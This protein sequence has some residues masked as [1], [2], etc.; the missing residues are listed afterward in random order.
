MAKD[1]TP[2]APGN[3]PS[4]QPMKQNETKQTPIQRRGEVVRQFQLG[5]LQK[6]IK[7]LA[8]LAAVAVL[9]SISAL[10][11]EIDLTT[12]GDTSLHAVNADFGG[13]GLVQNFT[14]HPAGTGVFDPFLTIERDANGNP[15]GIERGYN[16][17]GVLYLDQQR[18]HWNT[19]LTLGDLAV[20]TINGGS[21]YAFELDANEPGADK[22]IISVDNVRIYTSSSDNTSS[23]K[24][25]E[26]N[27][28]SLGDLRWAMN[29]PLKVGNDYKADEWIKL[30]ANLSDQL[31]KANGGSGWS[32]MILYV[33]VSAFAGA[34]PTDLVWFYNLNGVHI[35]AD[36][37]LAAEA[38]YEEWRATFKEGVSVPD[39][40]ATLILLGSAL[41][42]LFGYRRFTKPS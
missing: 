31:K 32:D 25:N 11:V 8:A 17:D 14:S 15:R 23:V 35:T 39:G 42:G 20:S 2:P 3:V 4:R 21:Y 18:P 28:D 37:N 30:D 29:N 36:G 9:P 24:N 7:T 13:G 6:P 41:T 27:L 1:G 40:G 16:T 22:S 38:G 26:N 19:L 34:L 33:P 5:T 10:A 12:P